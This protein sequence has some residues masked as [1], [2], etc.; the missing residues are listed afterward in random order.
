[1]KLWI[2]FTSSIEDMK[3]YLLVLFYIMFCW[4]NSWT[5]HN[6]NICKSKVFYYFSF[7]IICVCFFFNIIFF[8]FSST[9]IAPI[10]ILLIVRFN[11]PWSL[12]LFYFKCVY[13]GIYFASNYMGNE[14]SVWH[15]FYVS[16]IFQ[17]LLL[18]FWFWACRLSFGLLLL[19]D[20]HKFWWV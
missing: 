15:L 10:C 2:D 9:F 11:G 7:H 20:Y 5:Y 14:F 1:M 3:Q 12:L 8:K 18:W 17:F 16:A 19:F 6:H 13:I 4:T